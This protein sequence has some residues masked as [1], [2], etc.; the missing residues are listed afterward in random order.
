MIEVVANKKSPIQIGRLGENEHIKVKFP[1]ATAMLEEYPD[2]ALSLIVKRP[3]ED[4]SYPAATVEIEDNVLYWTITSADLAF[5]GRGQCELKAVVGSVVAKSIIYTTEIFE[6]LDGAGT[7]PEPWD[8]WQTEF[9]KVYD[10]TAKV[11]QEAK[12]AAQAIQDMGVNATTILPDEQASVDKVV[13]PDTGAVTLRFNIPQGEQGEQGEQGIR[14]ETGPV[15]PQGQVGESPQF[16]IGDVQTLPEGTDVS[17]TM[18]GTALNP[19]LNFA[20]PRGDTGIQGEVGERG[21]QGDPGR[22]GIDGQDGVIFTPHVSADG[23]LSWTNDGDVPNP[24]PVNI[25]GDPGNVQDVRVNGSSILIGGVANIPIANDASAGVIRLSQGQGINSDAQG[26]ISLNTADYNQIKSGSGPYS[27]ITPYSQYQ[28]VFYGLAKAAGD[29]TQAA[30]TNRVGNYTNNAKVAIKAMLGITDI[31]DTGISVHICSSSEYSA[32]TRMPT[33]T[34]PDEDTFYLVPSESST[35][36]DMFV[37]WIYVN[38]AWE[39]FGSASIDLSDYALKDEIPTRVSD[40]TDDSGHYTKPASGIPAAD[41]ANGVIHNVP[42]GGTTGQVL[43]KTSGTDYNVEWATPSG[44]TVEDVQIAGNSILDDGVANIPVGLGLSYSSGE[45]KANVAGDGSVKTGATNSALLTP[46]RQDAATFYGLSKIAGV[47]LANATV[48]PGT[49]PDNAKTAIRAMLGAT[50]SNVIAVQDTTPTDADTKIWLPETAETPVQ[51]PTVTEMEQALAEKV[52][53]VQVNGVSVVANGVANVPVA[54]LNTFGTV[55]VSTIIK[56]DNNNRLVLTG[57]TDA[58]IKNENTSFPL[59]AA[60]APSATFYGLAKAAGD[61]TQSQ[62]SNAVGTYTAEAKAAIQTMLG[63]DLSSIA[64]QVDI[65]LVETVTGTAVTITGQPNTRYMCG[66]VLTID[67][68]PPAS[69][70]ID[71]FF[72]SGTTAAVL[73]VPSTVKFPSWFDAT[74]LDTNTIYEILITDDVYGSVMT[75]AN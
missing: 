68:T 61:T 33:I 38:G 62:S 5:E 3:G 9:T 53:D 37:E 35:S 21:K 34:N 22:D 64:S 6:A 39:M 14:G 2:A 26:R 65:P 47:D 71:V 27:A 63:I 10:D 1:E 56:F 60:K 59:L 70:S 54:D 17:V 57:A 72:T 51:V 13:D 24:D 73:T 48:N 23:I 66:E 29:T 20:I 36:P 44:G 42:A 4:E 11:A 75:W 28:S 25:K 7:P 55:K 12:D 45:L 52:G 40:L 50:S 18:T 31:P 8:S 67:I 43:T 69:G 49:Y 30:S 58:Q 15:G 16:S 32:T 41:I 74:T 46:G 19:V